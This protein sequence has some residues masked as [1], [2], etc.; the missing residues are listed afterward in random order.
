MNEIKLKKSD[1][2]CVSYLL[3]LANHITPSPTVVAIYLSEVYCIVKRESFLLYL[4]SINILGSRRKKLKRLKRLQISQ[5][6]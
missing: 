4:N 5:S 1:L 2:R 3:F 6:V